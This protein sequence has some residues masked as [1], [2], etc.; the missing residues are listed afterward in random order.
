M[1]SLFMA[2]RGGNAENVDEKSLELKLGEA[3][4]MGATMSDE[5]RSAVAAIAAA[6]A[7]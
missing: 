6:C 4:A 2:V 7:L 1:M 3:A 5:L